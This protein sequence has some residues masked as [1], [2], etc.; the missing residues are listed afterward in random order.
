MLV[1][2]TLLLIFTA[3]SSYASADRNYVRLSVCL[4]HAYFVTKRKNILPIFWYH[5]KDQSLYFS[6]NNIG[7]G[8]IPFHL[9]F[10]V[11]VTHPL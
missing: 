1:I 4:S 10:A 7:W 9:K 2:L 6:E 8:D 3:R 11:K 5:M